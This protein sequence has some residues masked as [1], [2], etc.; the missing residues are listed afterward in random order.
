M[1]I[2]RKTVGSVTILSFTG[3]FD[4]MDLREVTDEMAGV[5]GEGGERMVFNFR[6]LTFIDSTWISYLVKTAKDLKAQGGELVLSEPSR[7]F[8]RVGQAIGID[9]IFKLFPGDREALEHFGEDGPTN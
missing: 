2:Q 3:E 4:A 7:F 6:D 8:S 5:L 1:D 9:R